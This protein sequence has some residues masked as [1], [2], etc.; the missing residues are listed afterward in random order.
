MTL[1]GANAMAAIS[2]FTSINRIVQGRGAIAQLPEE[3]ARFKAR[4]IL[5]VTDSGLVATPIPVLV[6]SFL[7]DHDVDIFSAVEP[8]PSVETINACAAYVRDKKFDLLI[9]LGGGSPID[10]AKCASV[11]ALNPGSA[12]DYLGIE[13]I[14]SA[15]IPKILIPTTAG[16]GSEVTNVAVL[17]LKAA[18]TKK[19]IVS[20]YMFADLAILDPELTL[21]LPPA[22]TA[23]TGMDALTHAIEAY[24]SRF[25]QPL[26][27]HFA[28]EAIRLIGRSLRTAVY[29]GQNIDA[30]EAMLTGSMYAGLAF[31]SA[32]TGMVHGLAMPLGGLFNVAH[33]I[34]NAV[35]LPHVMRHN[36]VS[37]LD[38]YR[39]VAIALGEHVEH[40]SVRQGAER[41]I[42]AVES[43]SAD[44][45]IPA[46]L[47]D[48]S[49]PKSAIADLAKDG[50][51]N[52]RQIRPN[53]RDVT[54]E[55]LLAILHGAFRP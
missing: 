46:Y 18:H 5:I 2:V 30:R 21:G 39:D 33:G 24:V 53:P 43:L 19:G 17:S 49:I 34:A 35:M 45:G 41:A 47:D 52:V 54:Y 42:S 7:K 26:T 15:G 48:L 28:L 55:G 10:T 1:T 50:M 31:G 29:N 25:A 13:K 8:D 3:L 9:G 6:K 38:R 20:R 14:E 27:D 51:N 37:S 16:T 22:V 36:L 32:A 23:S 44:I 40:L 11:L 12:E 4:K